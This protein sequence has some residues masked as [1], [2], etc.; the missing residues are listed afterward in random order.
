MPDSDN[1]NRENAPDSARE[2]AA[3]LTREL[4]RHNYLYHT[5]DEPEISDDAYDALFRELVEL[6]SRWPQL[7][8]P[9]SPT[10]RVGGHVLEGLEKM[11]HTK[12]M[13]GLDN[14]FSPEEWLAFEERMER[15]WDRQLNGELALNFW[16]DPKLDGLALEIVYEHGALV[17]A[18]TRGDGETGEIVTDA[19]RTIRNVPLAL[20]GDIFPAYLEVRGEVVLFKKDFEELNLAQLREGKKIF[21]NP[22]NAAAGTM[23]QLDVAV[24]ASRP[25]RFLAYNP[26]EIRWGD[27]P[28]VASQSQ[29]Q[30]MLASFGF[31][32]PPDG[33]LCMGGAEVTAYVEWAR[34]R[35]ENFPMEI[36]GVVAKLDSLPAQEALGFTARAPRFAV[37]FKFP[38]L[39]ATTK[40]LGI[41]VQVGRTGA[42]TPVANLEPALV[43]GVTVSHCTLH[44]EDEIRALDLRVGDTVVIQRAGDVIPQIVEVVL[45][46]R[47]A[48]STPYVFPRACPACGQPVF[49]E[50][51][52][53]VWRCDNLSCPA[54]RLRSILHFVS[55]AGLDIQGLGEKW[56]AQLV[57]TGKVK[58]PADLFELTVDD[59]LKYERMGKILA[60]KFIASLDE[61]KKNATLPKLIAALGIL[62]VGSQMSQGLATHFGG[63]DNLM[64]ATK[65]DLLAVYDV[66]PEVASAIRFFFETP[67]NLVTLARFKKMGL[68]PLMEASSAR[69]GGPLSGKSF[70]FTGTLSIP[71]SEAQ[72]LAEDAGGLIKNSVSK[73]LDYLVAGEKPGSKLDKARELGIPVLDE[74]EFMNLL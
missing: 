4:N 30:A 35:R 24:T 27:F 40:L 51:D 42:L 19:A 26:G 47:P 29:F 1:E 31:Q 69:G 57:E 9:N 18:L 72:K 13:Y 44:N 49:R 21:A 28:P 61:A 8:S 55:K 43:G 41:D 34:T 74:R 5:K 64:N 48:D 63:M 58:S 12:R 32:T 73:N 10:R 45:D 6:E 37:A 22:R 52:E 11:R 3:F 15:A 20:H 25:L 60:K 36:D 54:R 68:W 14:V 71:R 65:E 67:A 38:A 59:L 56:V 70:L 2:R 16:C 39:R 17:R 23:R 33:K 7:R 53:A 66:G 50:P 46:K 62:H